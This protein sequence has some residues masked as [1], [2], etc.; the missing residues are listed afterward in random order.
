MHTR[1]FTWRAI[2]AVGIILLPATDVAANGAYFPEQAFPAMPEI[3]V[4]RALIVWRDGTETLVVESSLDGESPNVGWVLPL[5]AEPTKLDV[6][7]GAM[8][9]SLTM[10][11]R[12]SITHDLSRPVKT[13][14]ILLCALIPIAAL[15]IFRTNADIRWCELG[16]LIVVYLVIL[17]AFSAMLSTAG[18][19]M[20]LEALE[21]G[22][23]VSSQQRVGNYEVSVLRAKSSDVLSEWLKTNSL[24]P[25]NEKARGIVD[26]YISE[27]W[28]FVVARLVRNTGGAATPHPIA[29]TFPAGKP[30]YPM[31]LTALA[32]STTRVELFVAADRQAE[33]PGFHV[34]TADR[35]KL[36]TPVSY[37]QPCYEASSTGLIIGSPEVG[38]FLWQDCVVTR[39]TADLPPQA[40]DRDVAIALTD[41]AAHRDH[42]YSARARREIVW[43]VLL[44]GGIVLV[45]I[46]AYLFKARRRPARRKIMWMPG[47]AVPA[48][49][50]AAAVYVLLPVV[51]VQT[52][53]WGHHPS[54]LHNRNHVLSLLLDRLVGHGKLSAEM[55][56]E[57]LAKFPETLL[58]AEY[59]AEEEDLIANPFTGQRMKYERSPGNFSSRKV[60]GKTWLCFYDI[61][62]RETRFELK[63]SAGANQDEP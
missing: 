18:G 3:P 26:R 50:A 46:C 28:C 8:L 44:C 16:L 37:A 20:G 41:L 11:Q 15:V 9:T 52:G 38:E 61:D 45:P 27:G 62:G 57:Q 56:P 4:Q 34:A 48:L 58:E 53:S 55:T 43:I 19:G 14:V 39:L 23:E 5:P 1:P 25:L 29:V 2:M 63:P 24:V 10:S 35:Y 12:A 7:D 30:I 21:H 13:L 40:M 31:R 32:G 49:I 51:P 60:E 59:L 17:L 54:Y 6:A 22:V 36:S 33:A 42:F 47:L